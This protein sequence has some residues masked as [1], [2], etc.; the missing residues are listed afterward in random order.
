MTSRMKRSQGQPAPAQSEIMARLAAAAAGNSQALALLDNLEFTK[1]GLV[2]SRELDK[3]D[4]TKLYDAIRSIKS[5]YQWII[6]DWMLYGFEH[7]WIERYED[8]AVFTGL[9][10]KTVKEYTYVCRNINASIR[11]D[12]LSFAHFQLIAPL[13]ET[14]KPAW[15][16]RAIDEKMSVRELRKAINNE[17]PDPPPPLNKQE[18]KLWG[19]V[20]RNLRR[21]TLHEIPADDV[22]ILPK[23]FEHILHMVKSSKR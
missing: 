23:L 13:P 6:G 14:D 8:M 7:G 16:Q 19:M 10:E 17:D 1:T 20:A 5:A 9:K 21:N 18:R 12:K 4:W 2:I 3:V 15:I 11:M 22:V